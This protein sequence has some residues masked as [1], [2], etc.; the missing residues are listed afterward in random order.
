M[1]EHP[2]RHL[3]L[4]AV[5]L[6]VTQKGGER[7]VNRQAESRLAGSLAQAPS[8]VP[9]HPEPIAEIDLTGVV[10]ALDQPLNRRLWALA[11]GQ[12]AGADMNGRHDLN[13]YDP[14]PGTPSESPDRRLLQCSRS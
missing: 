14:Y 10:A 6:D 12:P 13:E 1:V 8:E 11:R 9:V 3:V 2:D 4:A 7:R 5:R